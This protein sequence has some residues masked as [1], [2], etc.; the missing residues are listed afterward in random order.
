MKLKGLG[1]AICQGSMGKKEAH[2]VTGLL[3]LVSFG[4][5]MAD[6][7]LKLR[8]IVPAWQLG[9]SST[10]IQFEHKVTFKVTKEELPPLTEWLRREE[11]SSE[12]QSRDPW[13]LWLK[14][15]CT[16][17]HM[18]QLDVLLVVLSYP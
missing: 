16:V 17:S 12:R 1:R 8:R 2:L 13:I 18:M 14:M 11:E 5:A 10:T 3:L 9:E 4:V 15:K 6:D 7:V